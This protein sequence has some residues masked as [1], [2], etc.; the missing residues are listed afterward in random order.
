[1]PLRSVGH[2]G[3][4]SPTQWLMLWLVI[5]EA[6]YALEL[7]VR[8]NELFGLFSPSRSQADSLKRLEELGL[9]ETAPQ[10]TP[11]TRQ[12]GRRVYFRA[13]EEGKAAHLRWLSA[14][15]KDERWRV[16]LLTRI[17]TGANIGPTGLIELIKLYQSHVAK[18]AAQVNARLE[19]LKAKVESLEAK[20]EGLEAFTSRL[21][22]IELQMTL[23]AQHRF[24]EVALRATERYKRTFH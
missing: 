5:E 7:T 12:R 16:E 1:M 22:L 2:S 15:V 4:V 19:A 14:G 21:V 13:T 6:G 9:V 23:T 3:I 24:S 17:Y 20:A 8:Y 11:K 10:P 18:E